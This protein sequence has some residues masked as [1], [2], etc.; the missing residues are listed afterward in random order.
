MGCDPFQRLDQIEESNA[1]RY[2]TGSV[3]QSFYVVSLDHSPHLL[4]GMIQR[5]NAGGFLFIIIFERIV[6]GFQGFLGG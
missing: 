1:C 5:L 2:G 3:L 4:D 6:G